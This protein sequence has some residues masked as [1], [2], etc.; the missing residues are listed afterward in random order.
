MKRPAPKPPGSKDKSAVQTTPYI[1]AYAYAG[2]EPS[3]LTFQAGQVILVERM[4]GDW[5]VGRIG[6]K[7]GNFPANYVTPES[8]W[9]Q[10]NGTSPAPTGSAFEEYTVTAVYTY[11]GDTKEDL[12]FEAGE[13]IT[14][15]GKVDEFWL[16]G[17]NSKNEVGIFPS[18][19]TDAKS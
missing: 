8:E 12:R 14:V 15:V 9:N 4:D 3:D 11:E 2:N 16:Q 6:D 18:T 1:A 10:S 17:K 5:W 19:Y 13:K 7:R